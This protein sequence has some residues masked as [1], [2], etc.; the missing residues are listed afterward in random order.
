MNIE[1]DNPTS[2]PTM[3]RGPA[4]HGLDRWSGF[5]LQ[6]ERTVRDDQSMRSRQAMDSFQR[7]LVTNVQDHAV[8]QLIQDFNDQGARPSVETKTQH[9]NRNPQAG[10]DVRGDQQLGTPYLAVM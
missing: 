5:G 4:C 10:G 7:H 1:R 3:L 8:M 9:R 6:H 2:D